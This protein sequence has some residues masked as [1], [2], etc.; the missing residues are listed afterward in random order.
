M[1]DM[2]SSHAPQPPQASG[3]LTDVPA[4]NR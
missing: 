1:E 2:A 4:D 3:A